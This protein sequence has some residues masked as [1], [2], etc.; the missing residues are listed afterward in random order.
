[1]TTP[2]WVSTR[3]QPI[4]VRDVLRYLVG[5][6]DLPADVSRA[7]DIGGPDVLTYVDMMRRY[8]AVA[9][10][11]AAPDRAGAGADAATVRALGRAG[12]PGPGGDRATARGV[13]ART[14]WCAASTT[15]PGTSPT[16]RTGC[17]GSR[18]RPVAALARVQEANVT[19]RWSSASY[20][21][22]PPRAVA[23]RPGL[24]R[25]LAVPV[26]ERERP[27][28]RDPGRACGRCS[29]ASAATN[30]WYSWPLAWAVRGVLDRV[31]GGVGLRRGRRDPDRLAVG[32]VV[33][34]WRVEERSPGELLRLRAE[35]RLP[36]L[37]W[38]ELPARAV[39]GRGGPRSRRRTEA[40]GAVP[41]ARA[42]RARSTGGRSRRSTA[43]SSAR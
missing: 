17:S 20:P 6:A 12:D 15:S 10:L 1:M 28:R 16:R 39:R 11:P 9:G 25:R 19:T 43:S 5:A 4:A 36:G 29:R 8:A 23:Q 22:A 14:R 26:D 24:G 21:G 34:F 38:L 7:F 32:D 30:G 31:V 37:A 33:D 42:G 41:P 27:V 13:A 2:Q 18:P 3:I 35:M 40:A